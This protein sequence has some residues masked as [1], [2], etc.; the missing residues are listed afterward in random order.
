[1][2]PSDLSLA[3]LSLADSPWWK[4]RPREEHP[5]AAKAALILRLY[6]ALKRRSST[7]PPAFSSFSG[8]AKSRALS[9]HHFHPGL[10]CEILHQ[11]ARFL[12]VLPVLACGFLRLPAQEEIQI[13][14]HHQVGSQRNLIRPP[15][16]LRQE[17]MQQPESHLPLRSRALVN[18]GRHCART[19]VGHEILEQIRGNDRQP[20]EHLR[21]ASR[22]QHGY[23][24]L[25]GHIHSG[26]VSP[27]FKQ[28]AAFSIRFPFKIV[29]LDRPKQFQLGIKR[30]QC[31]F[32]SSVFLGVLG[33]P[34][35]KHRDDYLPW[36]LSA[37]LQ[38]TR[39]SADSTHASIE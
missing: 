4:S 25:G 17:L 7:L 23:R 19:Y 13:P 9:K 20:I 12:S 10:L 39:P 29:V 32:E 8:T 16:A 15:S 2:I 36:P 11:P 18:R 22:A 24:R 3:W 28:L 26:E 6:A 37:E 1:M 21:V 30:F 27:L 33:D 31:G 14:P 34:H 35:I 5:P 38:P